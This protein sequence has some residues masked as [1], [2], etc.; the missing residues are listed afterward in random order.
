MELITVAACLIFSPDT[1]LSSLIET[2]VE[3]ME[4]VCKHME[5][6]DFEYDE[7]V[8]SGSVLIIMDARFHWS[9]ARVILPVLEKNDCPV[10]FICSS[11]V[12]R[13]HVLRMYSGKCIAL[14]YGCEAAEIRQAVESLLAEE[15]PVY[16]FGNLQLNTLTHRVLLD[17]KSIVLTLQEFKLLHLLMRNPD[18]V[19]TREE[20]MREAWDYPSDCKTRTVDIHIGRLRRKIGAQWI[21]TVHRSGYRFRAV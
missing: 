15:E 7:S 3:D 14:V 18:A 21:E 19:V 16:S 1:D 6:A 8:F 10:L 12:N 17:G 20:L 11:L 5:T 4:L 2:A 9:K 13:N